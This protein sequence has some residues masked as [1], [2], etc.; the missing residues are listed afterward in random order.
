MFSRI[1]IR[2]LLPPSQDSRSFRSLLVLS[3]LCD[4][5][6]MRSVPGA[7]R[8]PSSGCGVSVPEETEE[9]L[10]RVAHG[11][12]VRWLLALVDIPADDALPPFHS[13][14][15]FTRGEQAGGKMFAGRAPGTVTGTAGGC[16]G[17][18]APSRKSLGIRAP[19]QGAG[20][21]KGFVARQGRPFGYGGGG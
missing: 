6:A 19:L 16:P 2:F 1:F 17:A 20:P 14:E 5:P 10:R 8:A 18:S 15:D 3:V 7:P 9:F 13:R 11:T 12:D 4:A 21:R